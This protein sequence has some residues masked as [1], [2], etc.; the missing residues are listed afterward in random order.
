MKQ[1]A[2]EQSAPALARSKKGQTSRRCDVRQSNRTRGLKVTQTVANL[3][4]KE[5]VYQKYKVQTVNHKV[6]TTLT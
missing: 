6:Q 3:V 1:Q 2:K 4:P 5:L